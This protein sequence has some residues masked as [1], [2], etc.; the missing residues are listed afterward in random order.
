MIEGFFFLS[1]ILIHSIITLTSK[2]HIADKQQMK[3]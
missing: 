2:A 1:S 3:I